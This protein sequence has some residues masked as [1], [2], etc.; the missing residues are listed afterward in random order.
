M[1]VKLQWLALAAICA[2]LNSCG[3]P[4]AAARTVGNTMST[5][6]SAAG[7]VTDSLLYPGG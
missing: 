4:A 7:R 2:S 3:L 1:K 6:M 5:A